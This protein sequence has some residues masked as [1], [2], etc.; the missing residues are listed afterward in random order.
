LID[1]EREDLDLVAYGEAVD[2]HRIFGTTPLRLIRDGK[3]K[4]IHKVNP[5]LYDVD[6]DPG[7]RVDLHERHPAVA[8]RLRDR[9]AALLAERGPPHDA[10]TALSSETQ[11][12]LVDLGYLAPATGTSFQDE[13]ALLEPVGEDPTTLAGDLGRIST[14]K[15]LLA[16]HQ[17]QNAA[18]RLRPVLER[19]PESGHVNGLVAEALAGAGERETAVSLCR[20][21]IERD[22]NECGELGLKLGRLLYSMKRYQQQLEVLADSAAACPDSP[23]ILNGYAWELASSPDAR[24][25]DGAKAIEVARRAIESGAKEA[26]PNHLDTLA[27]AYAEAG[28]FASAVREQ[29]R[30]V[31]ILERSGASES[32]LS[33]YLRSLREFEA[34]I[35]TDR[36]PDG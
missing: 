33:T 15:A 31:E 6:A 19:H 29:R 22:S 30:A 9:L 24:L 1:G 35:A 21:A 14:A 8:K 2:L 4:Y 23:R 5:E 27:A 3:W 28:D 10:T 17:W 16:R 20:K 26:D 32:D 36:P 25:R 18:D 11:R 12:Q 7:E 34:K 13:I